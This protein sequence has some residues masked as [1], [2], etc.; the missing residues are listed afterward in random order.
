MYHKNTIGGALK[1]NL[2]FVTVLYSCRSK[3][4][5]FF[6]SLKVSHRAHPTELNYKRA[7]LA[8]FRFVQIWSASADKGDKINVF[9][10]RAYAMLLDSERGCS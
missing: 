2:V 5:S 4:G 8:C 3:Y 10:N 9:A 6:E 7:V 1:I